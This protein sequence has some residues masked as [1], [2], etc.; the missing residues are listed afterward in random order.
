MADYSGPLRVVGTSLADTA[1]TVST[2]VGKSLLLKAVHVRYSASVTQ[3]VT[4]VLNSGAGA[5]Y[6][7]TLNTI[8]ISSGTQ[9]VYLPSV[10]IP[11]AAD[12]VVDVTAPAGGGV[13]TS[14]IAIYADR[15]I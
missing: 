7:V 3:N 2:T 12:D 14:S 5:A 4:V 10:P 9:G 15:Q 6:D 11:I 13:I 1:Q 8:A